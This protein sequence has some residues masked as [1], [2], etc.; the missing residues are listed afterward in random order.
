MRVSL[1][2]PALL[3]GVGL[4]AT[5]ADGRDLDVVVGRSLFHRIWTPAGASS[6]GSDGLGPQ[7]NARACASCHQDAGAGQMADGNGLVLRFDQDPRY[8]RQLQT[9]AVQG[10]QPEG[11]LTLDWKTEQRV[12]G[13]GT[14]VEL[15]SPDWRVMDGVAGTVPRFGSLRL[16]PSL[17]GLA[18]AE[19]ATA[20][21][22]QGG[23][24]LKGDHPTLQSAVSDALSLDLGLSTSDHPDPWGD[25]TVLEPACRQGPHGARPQAGETELPPQIVAALASYLRSLPPPAPR[26][27]NDRRGGQI[28]AAV[29]CAACHTPGAGVL[30]A[31]SDFMAH[32][33]GGSLADG[34][35]GDL[36]ARLWRTAPLWGLGEKIAASRPLLH[37]G[38]GRTAAEAILWHGGAAAPSVAAYAALSA[39]D[40]QRLANFLQ[41]L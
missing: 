1:A 31:Y 18:E 35:A 27:P 28:F 15:R 7:F 23:F 39:S 13:D 24:G 8:G 5:A 6:R 33:L 22:G 38:R 16:A 34:R 41:G 37:D 21:A 32:D 2:L 4:A 30:Q 9:D 14:K 25:C 19:R 20:A 11:R 36:A 10:E 12:L 3:L 17:R 29:G 26:G 40:R